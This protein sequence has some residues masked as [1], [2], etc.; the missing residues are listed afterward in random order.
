[1]RARVVC[2]AL[3]LPA[4]VAAPTD[5]RTDVVGQF[6]TMIDTHARLPDPGLTATRSRVVVLQSSRTADA[7]RLK[8]ANPHVIVLAYLNLSAMSAAAPSGFSTGVQTSGR[9]SPSRYAAGH[10][11]WYLHTRR[12]ARFTFWGYPWLWAANVGAPGYAARSAANAARLLAA[13]TAVGG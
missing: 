1:M 6:A 8:R 11:A 12:G 4:V 10:P 5:A 3:L 13:P 9:G 7:L 2:L